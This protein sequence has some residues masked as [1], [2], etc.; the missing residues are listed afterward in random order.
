MDDDLCKK[1]KIYEKVP[2]TSKYF[3]NSSQYPTQKHK[4]PTQKLIF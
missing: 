2:Q 4:T 1:Q 3:E